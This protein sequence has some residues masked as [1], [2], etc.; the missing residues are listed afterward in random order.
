M[1]SS[2]KNKDLTQGSMTSSSSSSNSSMQNSYENGFDGDMQEAK[3][4]NEQMGSASSGMTN[5]SNS[6]GVSSIASPSGSVDH[7]ILK[8]KTN[9]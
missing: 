6:S 3:K 9:G 7:L 1:T 4:Y 2:N 8:N 5:S